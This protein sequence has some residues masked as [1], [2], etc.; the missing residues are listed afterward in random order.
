MSKFI[1]EL[2][3]ISFN[4]LLTCAREKIGVTVVLGITL[5]VVA[6]TNHRRPADGILRAV[7]I[8]GMSVP[9]FWTATLVLLHRSYISVIIQPQ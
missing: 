2:E 4:E 9:T 1:R 7:S 8:L 3:L 5:G 6:A